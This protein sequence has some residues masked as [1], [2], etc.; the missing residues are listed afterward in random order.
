MPDT[1]LLWMMLRNDKNFPVLYPNFFPTNFS[2]LN[3]TYIYI[4]N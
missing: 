4:I 2:D 1:S 3:Y